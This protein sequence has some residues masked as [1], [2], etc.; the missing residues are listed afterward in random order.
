[1]EIAVAELLVTYTTPTKSPSGDLYYARAFGQVADDGLWEGW[2]EFQLA[3]DDSVLI[4]RRET[5]Q[6]NRADLMYWAQGLTDVYL[7]GALG[8][9]LRPA[10]A[11]PV[12]DAPVYTDSQ[13]TRPPQLRSTMQLRVVLDPYQVYAEGEGILRS[14]LRALS[15]D[16][17]QHI[18]EA[19]HFVDD[20]EF[21][22]A[23]GASASALA[24][25]IVERVR[26]KFD[27]TSRGRERA[28]EAGP[29]S[30]TAEDRNA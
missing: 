14:Q 18:V 19:Y 12:A 15:R 6:P 28:E 11:V 13:P 9:I 29:Q 30:A 5:E 16:H 4:T 21:A 7:E 20:N 17:L 25:R 3:G 1:L 22:F 27:L 8:R 23:Q 2:L 26:E 24:D 10:P